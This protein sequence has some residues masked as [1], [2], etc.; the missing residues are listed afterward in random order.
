MKTPWGITYELWGSKH[1]EPQKNQMS[2]SIIKK[3][4][5]YLFIVN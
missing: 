5:T 3:I 2:N 4:E 1:L